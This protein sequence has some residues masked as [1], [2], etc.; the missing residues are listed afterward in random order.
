MGI[1]SG[2]YLRPT[3]PA[4]HRAQQKV[5]FN[6]PTGNSVESTYSSTEVLRLDRMVL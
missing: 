4:V 2:L 6:Q 3:T 5:E 1:I